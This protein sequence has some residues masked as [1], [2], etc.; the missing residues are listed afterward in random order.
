MAY[1]RMIRVYYRKEIPLPADPKAVYRLVRA[2]SKA[3]REAVDSV[4]SEFF[5]LELDGYHQKRCDGELA[6]ANSGADK[7]RENGK[8]GG[9][10]RKDK[11][12]QEPENNLTGFE[13]ENQLGFK[14]NLSQTPDSRLQTP[15][16]ERSVS[17]PLDV[18]Q[19]KPVNSIELVSRAIEIAVYLRQRGIAG[20]NSANPNISAWADDARITNE[21]LDA[22]LSVVASRQLERPPGPGY[23]VGILADL[24]NPKPAVKAKADDWSRT[25]DGIERKG[26]EL[27]MMARGAESHDAFKNRIFDE[28]RK[29]EHA[30]GAAA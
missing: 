28:I 23:L 10:P 3:Q 20:A 22:A 26:R 15:E 25:A 29:R 30:Q 8:K 11:T 9:R 18:A 13:N 7:S 24:L 21:M 27:K 2:T 12:N 5:E 1:T 4:L 17:G 14:N 16:E 6:N 19:G